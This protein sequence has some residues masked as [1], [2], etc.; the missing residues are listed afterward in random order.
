MEESSRIYVAGH[1]VGSAILRRLERDEFQ[2]VIV[3]TR[4][5]CDLWCQTAVE[6]LFASERPEYVFLAAARVGGILAKDRDPAAFLYLSLQTNVIDAA[7]RY[8]VGKLVFLGSSCIYPKFAL[9]RIPAEAQLTG[10]LEL[11]NSGMPSQKSRGSSC[12]RPSGGNTAF[13]Q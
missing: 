1:L 2:N 3:R 9:Q 8:D 6:N 12:P 7:R 10:E 11:T 4:A 13:R 5:E